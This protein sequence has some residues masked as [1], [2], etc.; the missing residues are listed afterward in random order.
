MECAE[1]V[2]LNDEKGAK[3]FR[4]VNLE[5]VKRGIKQ[6]VPGF[7]HYENNA[8][9]YCPLYFAN[10]PRYQHVRERNGF[11]ALEKERNLAALNKPLMRE[12]IAEGQRYF[13][14]RLTGDPQISFEDREDLAGMQRRL[15]SLIG[16]ADHPFILVYLCPLLIGSR[17]REL[18]R[19]RCR[20]EYKGV[21]EQRLPVVG[22]DGAA[23]ELY[24]PMKM[25]L[26]FSRLKGKEPRPLL[27][28]GNPVE[29]EVS[30]AFAREIIEPVW[31]K[32]LAESRRA[33][34]ALT[35]TQPTFTGGE[36]TRRAAKA[37][38]VDECRQ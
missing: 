1:P 6:K 3:G 29:F 8:G 32:I 21:G 23:R 17:W 12:A 36:N 25:Q 18:G 37:L 27:S 5:I 38:H 22:L 11:D 10:N 20:V 33:A 31:P 9:K 26:C 35:Q 30:R 28:N 19:R 13:M 24:I 34:P 16:L 2:F 14:H 4:L 7:S 15:T